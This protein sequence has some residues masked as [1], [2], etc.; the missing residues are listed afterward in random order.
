M[1]IGQPT[2]RVEGPLKVTGAAKY[3]A[4]NYPAGTS[5]RGSWSVR[6]RPPGG[7]WRS[8][9]RARAAVPGVVRVMTP[10]GHA[11]ARKAGHV[12]QR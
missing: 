4:D 3:A 8:M 1:S 10:G 2:R 6:P 5:A 9:P 12:R 7:C 11:E